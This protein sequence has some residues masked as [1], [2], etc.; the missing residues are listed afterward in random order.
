MQ[1]GKKVFITNFYETINNLTNNQM[2]PRLYYEIGL[3]KI[4]DALLVK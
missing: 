4:E 3:P 1:L 2:C